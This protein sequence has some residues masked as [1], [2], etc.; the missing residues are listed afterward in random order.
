M[1]MV[2][3]FSSQ[4]CISIPTPC[5][6]Y[7]QVHCTPLVLPALQVHAQHAGQSNDDCSYAKQFCQ[8]KSTPGTCAN[9]VVAHAAGLT[10]ALFGHANLSDPGPVHT[11]SKKHTARIDLLSE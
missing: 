6:A 7:L 11:A 2:Q 4:L 1:L 9:V 10:T 5:N 3:V 8:L